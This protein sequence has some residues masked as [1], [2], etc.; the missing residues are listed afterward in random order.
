MHA[1]VNNARTLQACLQVTQMMDDLED[2]V[3]TGEFINSLGKPQVCISFSERSKT[4][5]WP[6]NGMCWS[7]CGCLVS[8]PACVFA[9]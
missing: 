7:K 5:L 9:M 1:T 8:Q 2:E 3:A 6:E 4:V